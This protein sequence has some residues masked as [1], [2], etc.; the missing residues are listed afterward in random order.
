MR[1]TVDTSLLVTDKQ[2]KFVVEQH[3]INRT[4]TK[5]KSRPTNA[6]PYLAELVH[7][8]GGRGHPT[9]EE[10]RGEASGDVGDCANQQAKA[11]LKLM[12]R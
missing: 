4:G 9:E 7:A 3:F 5:R 2:Q 11:L 12:A 10:D 8:R 1:C 6:A